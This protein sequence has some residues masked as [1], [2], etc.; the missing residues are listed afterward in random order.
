MVEWREG[1]NPYFRI[2]KSNQFRLPG[3]RIMVTFL[4]WWDVQIHCEPSV[5]GWRILC[6]LCGLWILGSGW[7]SRLGSLAIR[8]AI[9]GFHAVDGIYGLELPPG[10]RPL[11]LRHVQ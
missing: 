5:D 8:E 4:S 11:L 1:E 9:G 7:S 2:E 6:V 10:F 3:Y